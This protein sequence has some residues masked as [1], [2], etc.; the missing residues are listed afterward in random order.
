MKSETTKLSKTIIKILLK[1]IKR[2]KGGNTSNKEEVL[3]QP[4]PGSS[5]VEV[6]QTG[7]AG[8]VCVCVLDSPDVRVFCLF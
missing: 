5:K 1:D 4:L 2:Q 3:W 8:C 7:W 6:M